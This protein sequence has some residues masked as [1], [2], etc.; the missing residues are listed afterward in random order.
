MK[1]LNLNLL[2]LL[3]LTIP[4]LVK[5]QSYVGH[6]VDNYSG[7]HGLISNPSNV[8]DSRVKTD[9]NLFSASVFGGSDYFGINVGDVIKSDGGFDFEADAEK[10][11][12]NANNFFLN[13]DILGPSFMFNLTPKSSIGMVSRV[14]AFFNI[15]NISGELYENLADNFDTDEDF[16]FDSQNLTGTIHAWAEVGLVYGRVLMDKEQNFLKG[17]V[18]LKYL[19][20]AGGVFINSP[21]FTGNYNATNETLTTTGSLQYGIS[22]DFDNDDIEFNNLTSGFGADIGFTYEFRPRTDLDSLTKKHNKYKLK[23][24]ASITDIGSINYKESVVTT[25][26][27]N[28]TADASDYDEDTEDFLDDNYT[29]TEETIAQKI[30]LPTAFHFLADYNIKNKLFVSLQTNLSLV[31]KNTASGNNIINSVTIAPRLETK[32]FSIYSP[33]SFRQY[34][35]FAWGG[36]IRL[37]PLMVGSGSILSN[38]LSDTTKTTD[39]YLGLKIPIYQ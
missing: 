7:V 17:G 3:I 16:I 24:G 5:A 23:I 29:S 31:K 4:N 20:G 19:Q 18:T 36:G 33:V 39:V 26:D 25:Y 21:S 27:L 30:N 12:S 37:G 14:R 15:N 8:V 1:K 38:L 32:W 34:G 6:S 35:D 9:V 10:F 28:A 22:Q 13:A 11:P 2:V